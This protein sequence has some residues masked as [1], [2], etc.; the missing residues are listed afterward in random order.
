MRA[1]IQHI[2]QELRNVYPKTEIR[3]FTRLILE[4]VCG[5]NFTQQVLMKDTTL[6]DSVKTII[7]QLV[8]R[9]KANE[10]IQYVLGE[11][12]FMDQK[13]K[14]NPAVL[15][16]RPETGELVQWVTETEL[17]AAPAVIDIGTGSGCIALA[18]KKMF[19]GASVSA[20][21][22]SESALEVARENAGLNNLEVNFFPADVLQWENRSWGRYDAVVSNPPYVREQEKMKM[23]ANVL[24]FEPGNALFVKDDDPLKFYRL[25]SGFASRYLNNGGWLFFEF[26]ENFGSEMKSLAQHFGFKSI[27]IRNDLFGKN[28]MLRCRK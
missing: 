5:L 18:I 9:L 13:L 15:I 12:E 1:T 2:E 6:D 26:N 25:I 17:P 11:T 24:D 19:P 22:I 7:Y 4:H 14:V 20:V 8:K 21:D 27:E 23:A 16:P 3:A 28:R 10:P